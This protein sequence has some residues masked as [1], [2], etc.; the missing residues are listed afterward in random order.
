MQQYLVIYTNVGNPHALGQKPLTF[1]RQVMA[2]I[3]A[4]FMLDDP[5][6]GSMFPADA[7]ARART[8]LKAIG[9]MGA[10]QDS[11]G[12]MFIR[13]EI[14]NFITASTGA[15]SDPNNI[16]MGN[17]ASEVVRNL[18]RTMITDETNG[19]MVPIPQYPLYSASIALYGGTMCGYYLDESTGW[20]MDI[21]ELERSYRAAKSKG[22]TPRALVFINPGNPTGQCLTA[23]QLENLMKV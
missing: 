14:S 2:L 17:G 20:G 13:Q 23:E 18:M 15:H 6:I 22:V 21:S 1:P 19:V 3:M 9:G 11:K 5:N 4:P 16:F 10:Y 7:I 12:N 8:Y